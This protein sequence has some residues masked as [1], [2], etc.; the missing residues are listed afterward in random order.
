M[1]LAKLTTARNKRIILLSLTCFSFLFTTAQ[2]NSP[3]SRYGMGDIVPNQNVTSRGMGGIT[4]GVS[5]F[6]SLNL[7]NPAALANLY[8]TIFELGGE[9]DF[10]TLKSNISPDKYTSINTLISYL[11]LGFPIASKK[12]KDKGNFLGMSF[13]LRPVTRINYKIEDNKRIAGIDSSSTLFEGS[14]GINQVNVGIGLKV[15]RFSV[16]FNSGYSFGHK[17]YSTK[18]SLIN[19]SVLY[20][21]SNTEAQTRFGGLF[22][23]A[24]MQYEMPTKNGGLLRFG[25]YGN[26]E[27]KLKAKRDNLA[28]TFSYDGNGSI[29]YVDTV[30]YKKDQAGDIKIP[31]AFGVGFTY[32]DKNRHLLA[33]LDVEMSNWQDFTYYGNKDYTQKSWKIKAGA[34]YYPASATT[35]TSKY[36]S[37]VN[38]RAGIFYGNDYVSLN[39]AKHPEYGIT[40]GAG[41]PLT[42]FQRLRFG[43]FVILNTGLELGARGNKKSVS[44]RENVARFSIGISMNARWFQ[45]RKYD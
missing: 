40:L 41:L 24:G 16:G 4:A 20:F 11:Q 2:E 23:N 34:Q 37:F 33:G 42:S 32:T 45:N 1:H 31:S 6:Q 28:A 39:N 36:W 12:M 22:L 38:Y 26:L 35:S 14:G 9:L 8:S 43:E 15:K 25:A 5:D 19:D 44:I 17:D 29:L 27:Q 10:R 18:V 30:D 13:G 21:R 3:Y 7:V